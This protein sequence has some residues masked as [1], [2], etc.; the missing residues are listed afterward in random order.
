MALFDSPHRAGRVALVYSLVVV[1]ATPTAVRSAQAVDAI[2]VIGVTPLHGTGVPAGEY[3]ANVQTLTRDDLE[4]GGLAVTDSLN[5]KLSSVTLNAA[6]NN[7]LQPDVQYRGFTASPLLG[8]PQGIA[9]Y[10]DGVRLNSV[11]GDTVHWD[12]IPQHA[13]GSINLI[14]G[15]NPLFGLNTLGG[16]LSYRTKD[17]FTTDRS[18]VSVLGGSFDR[19]EVAAETGAQHGEWAYYLA[20]SYF[21]EEGWRDYS[22]S[23]AQSLFGKVSWQAGVSRLDLGINIADSDLIGNGATPS[24]LLD[25]DREAIFTRPDQTENE[26]FAVTLNGETELNENH[27]DAER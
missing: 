8:L 13:I 27:L 26:L 12:M 6:Q 23:T 22:P 18:R 5:R 11:F 10:G 9:V 20:L 24:Q 7:P 3:P 14:P 19:W 25:E 4:D 16:A 15:S 2:E 21:D 17:G 1:G